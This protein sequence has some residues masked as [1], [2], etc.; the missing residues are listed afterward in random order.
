MPLLIILTL[1]SGIVTAVFIFD[2][3]LGTATD[4]HERGC[5]GNMIGASGVLVFVLLLGGFLMEL[6]SECR[7]IRDLNATITSQTSSKD[8]KIEELESIIEIYK[9]AYGELRNKNGSNLKAEKEIENV[10]TGV[11]SQESNKAE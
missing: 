10:A 1:M 8:S 5:P 3:F 11:N 9:V 6:V 7:N 4:K 2:F